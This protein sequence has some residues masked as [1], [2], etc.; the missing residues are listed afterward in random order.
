MQNQCVV[1]GVAGASA[2]G[3][4]LFT[5]TVYQELKESLGHH[6]GVITE[7][8]YYLNQD[9]LT[10]AQ[11]KQ[12]NY[13]HPHSMDHQL[14]VEH[15]TLLRQGKSVQIP[16]YC[17]QTYTRKSE[18]IL[19]TPKRVL[20]IE[21][22]LLLSDLAVREQLDF[23]VFIDTPLDICLLRRLRRDVVERGRTIDSIIAQYQDTVRPM[24]FQ[25]VQP[26]KQFADVIVPR[27]GKN[28]M[29]IECL[30]ASI[31]NAIS[32]SI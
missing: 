30:K 16:T 28:R 10:L 3:K 32:Q 7:D 15:I 13:D 27:G 2:S 22:I 26:S 19:L 29:A 14:L 12:V 25:F 17:Y 9:H 20:I 23:S 18:K 1:V 24:Y 4:S 8:S 6:I 31:E 11:R 21:G 5:K